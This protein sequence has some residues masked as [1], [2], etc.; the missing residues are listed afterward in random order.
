MVE[1]FTSKMGIST[2]CFDLKDAIRDG[3]DGNIKGTTTQV[4]NE[5]IP[6]TT[7]FFVQSISNSCS[8]GFVNYAKNIETSNTSCLENAK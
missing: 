3:E 1:I 6:L 5:H 4:K 2:R 7:N 8:G